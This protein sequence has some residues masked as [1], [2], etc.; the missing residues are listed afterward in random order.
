MHGRAAIHV[1]FVKVV[2]LCPRTLLTL[3]HLFFLT[4]MFGY[5]DC[6]KS[7][8]LRL[9]EQKSYV[10]QSRRITQILLDSRDCYLQPRQYYN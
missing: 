1:F 7:V 2:F 4:Q 9:K 3:K 6:Q 8:Y 5:L 10:D